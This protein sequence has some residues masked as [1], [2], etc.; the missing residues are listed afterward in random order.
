VASVLM[1]ARNTA[2]M[3]ENLK[4]VEAIPDK[5]VLSQADKILNQMSA[6]L[7]DIDNCGTPSYFIK[8]ADEQK[9]FD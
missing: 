5:A 8:S 2:Q 1:G 7:T 4:S 9:S 6:D 3:E